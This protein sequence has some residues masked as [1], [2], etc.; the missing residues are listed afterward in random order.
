LHTV[1]GDETTT[2]PTFDQASACPDSDAASIGPRLQSAVARVLPALEMTLTRLAGGPMPPRQM[3]QMAR[4]LGSLT[5]TLRELN[6]LL[7]RY[8]TQEEKPLDIDELR[9][10]LARRVEGLVARRNEEM[11]RRYEAAWHEFAAEVEAGT[12]PG[13]GRTVP[14]DP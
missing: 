9:R 13:D 6:G 11:P 1:V 3:E 4:A 8:D 12:A 14:A 10:E 5:R 7:A 2:Q